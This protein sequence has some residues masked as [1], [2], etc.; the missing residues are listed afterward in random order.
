MA[1]TRFFVVKNF[2]IERIRI[3]EGDRNPMPPENR[4]LPG[5]FLVLENIHAFGPVQSFKA[6]T[7]DASTIVFWKGCIG[8]DLEGIHL[9]R[10]EAKILASLSGTGL[11]QPIY[12]D[13]MCD[14]PYLVFPWKKFQSLLL[15]ANHEDPVYW[16]G[17][18]QEIVGMVSVLHRSGFVHG[19]I[20]PENLLIADNQAYLIDF[21]L[22]QPIGSTFLGP[23]YSP[24]FLAPEVCLG[25]F[26]WHPS[27]DIFAL[28]TCMKR[29]LD[30]QQGNRQVGPKALMK[31]M[32]NLCQQMTH[33]DPGKRPS[34]QKVNRLLMA[35]EIDALS[36]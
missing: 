14:T 30:Q 29:F 12:R 10:N 21:G 33:P 17:R 15:L 2:P 4:M 13:V 20:R 18:L 8:T 23:I 9:I 1:F 16:L 36:L 25:N 3:S 28:G 31:K 22:G 26:H 5:R 34:S 27:T 7:S 19:D 32:G 24:G 35:L 11:L 6:L